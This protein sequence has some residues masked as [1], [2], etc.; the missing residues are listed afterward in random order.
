M[1]LT[2]NVGGIVFVANQF[3]VDGGRSF[4]IDLDINNGLHYS[5]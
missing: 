5:V 1:Y 3:G 4:S 2:P